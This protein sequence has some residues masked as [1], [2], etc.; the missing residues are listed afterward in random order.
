MKLCTTKIELNRVHTCVVSRACK[1]F[2]LL[3]VDMKGFINGSF[4]F[5]INENIF[6]QRLLGEVLGDYV[7]ALREW[8]RLGGDD[9]LSAA[10]ALDKA[11]STVEEII[12]IAQQVNISLNVA[13]YSY[14]LTDKSWSNNF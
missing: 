10:H 6:S 14:V 3:Y 12:T 8:S 13:V 9:R 7:Y 11:R 2:K 5:Q 4:S 1:I